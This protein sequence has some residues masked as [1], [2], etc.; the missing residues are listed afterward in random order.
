M[1]NFPRKSFKM[2]SP[3]PPGEVLNRLSGALAKEGG[4]KGTVTGEQ[5]AIINQSKLPARITGTV[6]AADGGSVIEAR[7][8]QD[9]KLTLGEL[10]LT[11][12][13]LAF[14]HAQL[15]DFVSDAGGNLLVIAAAAALFYSCF[16]A[17][18]EQARGFLERLAEVPAP[19]PGA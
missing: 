14:F 12:V 18:A 9:A 3:L 5:F 17:E 4:L 2:N 16:S 11:V 13:F 6:K 10:V 7:A 15:P 8:V 19:N 1:C